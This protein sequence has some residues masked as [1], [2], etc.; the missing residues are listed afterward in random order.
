LSFNGRATQNSEI[1]DTEF[2]CLNAMLMALVAISVNMILPA[3]QNMTANFGLPD[4]N[5]IGLSVTLL[6]GGLAVGQLVF[7]PLSDSFGRKY[8]M[9]IGL[10]LFVAGTA[11]SYF[12]ADFTV[13]IIG[14]IVQGIG[15]GA[16]RVVSLAIV[17]DRFVGNAMGRIMSFIMVIFVMVPTV[18]PFL[19]Q[20]VILAFDWRSLFIVFGAAGILMALWMNVRLG[21]TLVAEKR[22]RYSIENLYSAVLIV[23]G[24]RVSMGY[25]VS[26]GLV[27]SAFIAYLNMSQQILQ[28]QYGLG[29]HYPLY[30][31]A[32][33]LSL[34]AAS[35]M[36]GRIVLWLGME[37]LSLWALVS[38]CV[39]SV[40][41][42]VWLVWSQSEPGLMGLMMYLAAM[43]FG[44]GILVSN[45]NAL[46]MRSLGE[47][48]GMGAAIVGALS[49]LISIPFAIWI[50]GFYAGSIL[51]L[52]GG[53]ALFTGF[54]LI[55]FITIRFWFE[56][57]GVETGS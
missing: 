1:S 19:G 11:I 23:A 5:I 53:F 43:L 38:M 4:Q 2:I 35:F 47:V 57:P 56:E 3:F 49:T 16:P 18:S 21:E 39:I 6:F 42:T 30:F 45:L 55:L 12:S 48:A 13:L 10:A 50:G 8:A 22:S 20:S 36:N 54:A 46:A 25:A 14:Q 27:S 17:R 44:F 52:T 29:V 33:S 32:L 37:A 31:G 7:G 26:L 9:N 51:P 40:A 15:L 28:V 34:A 24:S 41:G